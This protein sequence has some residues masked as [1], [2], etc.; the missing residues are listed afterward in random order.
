V[1]HVRTQAEA[2]VPGWAP[3]EIIRLIEEQAGLVPAP[4][5]APAVADAGQEAEAPE[6]VPQTPEEHLVVLDAGRAI[7][8]AA[9][10][11]ELVVATNRMGGPPAGFEYRATLAGRPYGTAASWT[12]LATEAGRGRP[13]A[14][15]P[16][17]FEA[18]A[19]PPGLQRL[20]LEMALRL[21]EPLQEQPRLS[22]G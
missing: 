11:I 18:V 15:L 12:P 5:P 22:L 8:G 1:T 14:S 16:V 10:T 21:A 17:R 13:P 4:G 2:P 19:I 3:A 6:P 9:R 7:G 20:R